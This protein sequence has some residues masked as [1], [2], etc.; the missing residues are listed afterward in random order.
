MFAVS[1]KLLK[2]YLTKASN[3]LHTKSVLLFPD[4]GAVS[5]P[6]VLR[7]YKRTIDLIKSLG[8]YIA[9]A[10]WG[11]IKKSNPDPD[12]FQG[13]YQ[14]ISP[15]TFFTF[16]LRYS[17]YF[18]GTDNRNLVRQFLDLAQKCRRRSITT[19]DRSFSFSVSIS[20]RFD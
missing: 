5:N 12:E 9:I 3:I 1:P 6:L 2:V 8:F 13:D 20:V 7:Q 14:V 11:Q 4:A 15:D 17:A 18:P 19:G 10:W 16:G